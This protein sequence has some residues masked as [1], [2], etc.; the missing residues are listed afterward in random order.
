MPEITQNK[1]QFN[2]DSLTPGKAVFITDERTNYG[3]YAKKY[4][5]II[6]GSTPLSLDVVYVE[7]RAIETDT[8]SIDQVTRS[9]KS[10]T[11]EFLTIQKEA[12][13]NDQSN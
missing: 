9:H 10:V 4:S 2:T 11:I 6:T 13:K 8:F 3:R 7:D 5:A 12:S 1:P